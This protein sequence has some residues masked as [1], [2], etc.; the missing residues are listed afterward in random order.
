M[1]NSKNNVSLFI[2]AL[3]ITT[4]SATA[5]PGRSR[6][7]DR[8]AAVILQRIEQ[9]SRTFRTDLRAVPV[10]RRADRTNTLNDINTF[11][12]NFENA[13]SLFRHQLTSG[14]ARATDVQ[15]LLETASVVDGFMAT[16]RVNQRTQ[17]D[18]VLV[19]SN[20][21]ALAKAY[22]VTWQWSEEMPA[23]TNSNR[24]RLSNREV[25][26]LV[27]RIDTGG[28][29]FRSSLTE[30]FSESR[31]DRTT[32]ERDMNQVL[33]GFKSATEDLRNQQ[34]AGRPVAVYVERVVARAA[35]IDV[36]MQ[37]NPL[38]NR[39][40]TDWLTVRG[41]LIALAGAYD[42]A[43]SPNGDE[44]PVRYPA[45]SRLT[46]TFKLNAAN[47]DNPRTIA[48]R[49]TRSVTSNERQ[50]ISDRVL[51]RL[52]SPEML[53]IERRGS[54]ITLA[55]S[56]ARQQTFDAD[57]VEHQEPLSSGGA[58]RTIATLSGDQLNISSTGSRDND[59]KVT[60]ESIDNGNR[61]R[62]TREIYAERMNQPIVVNSL[63]DRTAIAAQWNVYNGPEPILG[64]TSGNRSEFIVGDGE[65]VVAVLNDGLTSKETR[66]GDRFGMTVREGQY[67]GAIITGTV[68]S[69]DQGGRLAGRSG[70]SL[71]FDTIRLRD[72]RSYKFA[73]VLANVRTPNGDKV[74]V[75]N[76]GGAQGDNQTR[77]T[78]QRGGIGTA[79][80]AII[81]AI[82]GGAKG[83]VIGAVVGAAGGA[84][85][86]YVQGQDNFELPSGTEL[87]I[88]AS[89]PR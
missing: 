40:Q 25:A 7:A 76:E 73:G 37:N 51:A 78:I 71:D 54:T 13:T 83:A 10:Q 9:S 31:Y 22:G 60:F 82:A 59:F 39:A 75:D 5:Q 19:R 70:L 55:S 68:A 72:G 77:Q 47:S 86:V 28:D 17:S 84:G 88:R 81:G 61:M 21:N 33:R 65:T 8:E 48:E 34:D 67:E 38:T 26:Q 24:S 53:A 56:K 62:V 63:Y 89:A 32:R 66:K 15:Q 87:T 57:G 69:V 18:W 49:A 35:P 36:F 43:Y 4:G 46:G 52:E 23:G 20:L 79:I 1:K 29:A 74:K 50:R 64:A 3:A 44:P 12:A 11:Q 16:N 6:V 80:G 85:S 45:N 14:R 30:A 58:A 27:L 42:I 41:D 2:L